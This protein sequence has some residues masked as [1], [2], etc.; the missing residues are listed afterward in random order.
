M[1]PNLY[2]PYV[3]NVYDGWQRLHAAVRQELSDHVEIHPACGKC[4]ASRFK[5]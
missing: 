3:A 2:L 1:L 5:I 4:T